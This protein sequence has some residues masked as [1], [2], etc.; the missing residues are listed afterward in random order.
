LQE[1]IAQDLKVNCTGGAEFYGRYFKCWISEKHNV[2]GI[3]DVSKGIYQSCDV[4][5]YTLA[6]KLGIDRIAKYATMFGLGQKTGIDLPQEVSGVMPSEEWKIRN[7]KQKWFA[8][9]TIS[10]GIGQGAVAVTP[11]QLARAIGAIASGGSLVRPHV[12]FPEDM[13]PNV[14]P[15][16]SIPDKVQ[17]ALDP[18]N[19]EII[20]DAMANVTTPLGTA[21]AAHLQD[22]D[23][24]GKTGTAQTIGNTAKAKVANGKARFKDNVWFVGVSPRRSP[25]IVVAV[26]FEAGELS[27]LAGIAAA[28]VVK[29]YVEK[30]RRTPTK[31]AEKP[32]ADGKVEIGGVWTA[33]DADGREEKLQGGH[34]FLDVAKRPLPAASTQYLVSG[35]GKMQ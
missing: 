8:G 2:H 18:K 30:Q 10:V 25:E 6:E 27:P 32:R 31:M 23:F 17:I 21:N 16:A 3:V 26:L 35:T 5:F 22:I 33:P 14:V 11:I 29:A 7:F 4:F 12:A 20:T 28:K 13:P 19:W 1:G 24:A 34:F 15:V 9:E